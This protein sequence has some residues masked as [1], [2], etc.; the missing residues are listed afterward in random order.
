MEVITAVGLWNV[1]N[2]DI[3]SITFFDGLDSAMETTLIGGGP[4]LFGGIINTAG[5]SRVEIAFAGGGNGWI[6]IDDLQVTLDTSAIPEPAPL[7]VMALGL[8]GLAIT[9]RRRAKLAA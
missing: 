6:T 5:A 9:R 2:D 7:S 4:P 3:I 1:S 8:V